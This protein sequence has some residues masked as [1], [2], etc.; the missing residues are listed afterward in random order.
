V[1]ARARDDQRP[2]PAAGLAALQV[3]FLAFVCR[4]LPD[5]AAAEDLLQAAYLKAAERGGALRQG[6]SSVAWFYRLLRNALVDLHRA[7][8]REAGALERAARGAEEAEAGLHEAACACIGA[9][10]ASLP[11]SQGDLIRH[12]DLAGGAVPEVARRLGLTPNAAGVRLHRARRALRDRLLQGC[13]A[14]ARH[15]CLDCDCAR[16]GRA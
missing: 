5:P 8:R 14:C 15:G 10:V 2:S 4:R 9:A 7:R 1:P 16:R 12:V 11:P 3:E 13:G 6:E